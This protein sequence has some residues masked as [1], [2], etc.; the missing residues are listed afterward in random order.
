MS[1][2]YGMIAM[3]LAIIIAAGS[4]AADDVLDAKQLVEK[5]QQ[6]LESFAADNSIGKPVRD[7]IKKAHGVFVAPEILRGAFIVGASGGS[8]VLVVRDAK[9]GRWGGPAFYTIGEGSF[10]FQAG[11]DKSET[12]LLI[13]T[14]RGVTAML[15]S[16]LKLGADTSVAAG[17]VGAGAEATTANLSAD[18][19]AF[20][21]AKGLYGGLSLEGAVVKTRN[22]WNEAFYKKK[23]VSPTDIILKQ[24]VTN[25]TAKPLIDQV[26]KLASAK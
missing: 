7:L 3:S 1:R 21:R 26:S 24:T 4:A 9:S 11:V 23:D 18:I 15:G 25:P 12:V 19:L 2:R 5:A 20:S 13:M 22:G 6:T 17:P 10:G 14:E 8:G 16:S